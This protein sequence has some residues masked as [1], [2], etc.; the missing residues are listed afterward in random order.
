[1]SRVSRKSELSPSVT[2]GSG[3]IDL[4]KNS[5]VDMGQKSGPS[6][7]SGGIGIREEVTNIGGMSVSGGIEVDLTPV[8]FGIN[9]DRSEGTISVA[10]EAEVPGGLLGVSGGIEVDLNTGEIIGGSIGGEVGGLGINVSNSKKGGLGV[11]FTVQIPGTPIELSLGFG[12]P[13][14]KP[15][16]TPT[17][18]PTPGSG[19]SFT[20]PTL[21]PNCYYDFFIL[22]LDQD[23]KVR[24]QV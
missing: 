17:P 4:G 19:P 10:T 8:D 7:T 13:P 12:F 18:T 14:K 15:A 9:I 6:L 3:G 22:G 16:P 5:G 2:R 21:D 24:I 1:M 23:L 11:E 20:M